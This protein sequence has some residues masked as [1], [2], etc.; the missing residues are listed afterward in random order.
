MP[1]VTLTN[2]LGEESNEKIIS[3]D[4]ETYKILTDDDQSI[5]WLQNQSK[6][7]AKQMRNY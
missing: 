5:G 3:E 7:G 6:L 1:H 2:C 4:G